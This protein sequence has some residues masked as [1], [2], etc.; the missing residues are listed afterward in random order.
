MIYEQLFDRVK[1]PEIVRAA[2]IGCGK[3]GAA[4]V[5]Q[6]RLIP[7]LEVCA[8]ADTDLDAA[9]S[10]FVSAGVE[11]E[12]IAICDGPK[13]AL[14]AMEAGKWV[15]AEDAMALMGLP[16][17]VIVTATGVPEAAATYA[18]E[19]IRHGKHVVFVDKEADS[20]VGPILKRLADR[21]GVVFTTD[22]GDQPGLVMGMVSWARALGLEVLCAGHMHELLY[23]QEEGTLA[24]T[25]GGGSLA[26]PSKL[27]WALGRIP[28]G[29]APRYVEARRRLTAGWQAVEENGDS[30]AHMAV[31]ANGTG[32]MPDTSG[33]HLPL[34]RLDE[35]P[36]VLCPADDG[37]ILQTRGTVELPT[38]L[39]TQGAPSVDGGIFVIVSNADSRARDIM[40][41]KGLLTNRAR[42]AMLI[43]RQHH[44]CGAET[45]ISILCAGLL[46]VPTGASTILPAADIAVTARRDFRVG[47]VICGP[48]KSSVDHDLRPALIPATPLADDSPLPFFLLEG[49]R[50]AADWPTGAVLTR[51]MVVAPADSTL[52]SLRQQQDEIFLAR[53]C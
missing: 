24:T 1:E 46:R 42:S 20:V 39:R 18:Y 51:R 45:A 11:Q 28:E 32:L 50:L 19:A 16:V 6:A 10:A 30:L 4:I 29:Q 14:R 48:G 47:E 35:L 13:A 22:D 26:V 15:V 49:N 3:F 41:A 7:R 33:V 17:H 27:R 8:V 9:R 2:L 25:W 12:G 40:I 44:L 38:I 37:G 31:T 5:T 43:Y 36:E 53:A 23:S 34:A 52:W 21:A